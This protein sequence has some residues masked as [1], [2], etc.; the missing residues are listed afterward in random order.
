MPMITQVQA[1]KQALP[2]PLRITPED[3]MGTW[4]GDNPNQCSQGYSCPPPTIVLDAYLPYGNKFLDLGAGGPSAFT[5]TAGTNDSFVK[6]SQ[7]SGHIT[8]GGNETRVFISIDWSKVTG[9]VGYAVMT[10]NATAKGQPMQT[11]TAFIQAMHTKA[12]A[13]FTGFVE[14]DGGISIEAEHASRNTSVG[15]VAWVAIPGLGRTLSAVTPWPRMGNNGTNYTAGA[16]PRLEY[17]FYN[18]HALDANGTV[19]LTAYMSPSWNA[20]GA[21]RPLAL[22]FQVDD[23]TPVTSYF[24]TPPTTPGAT[25]P[26]WDGTD[27]WVANSFIPAH[28]KLTAVPGAH[29]LKVWMIE[30]AVVVQKLVINTG[31]V[32]PSYLG[33]PESVH[34]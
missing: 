3:T 9:P 25:P 23:G 21:D 14:G 34:V 29:T 30:P 1:K 2:G 17:D 4:P 32:R 10:I 5:W 6:L 26:G 33:P 24:S 12:P 18:F 7:T 19:G 15:E 27:G 31:N 22:A 16:G 28:V 20:N 8:P 11:T 13:N